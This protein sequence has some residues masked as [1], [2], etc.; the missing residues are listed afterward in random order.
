MVF[1]LLTKSK[2]IATL[3]F[4]ALLAYQHVVPP[5]T[6]VAGALG[7]G[8]PPKAPS[9]LVASSMWRLNCLLK[10]IPLLRKAGFT[11]NE[12]TGSRQ[13]YHR[14][15]GDQ[16][17]Q[18][19]LYPEFTATALNSWASRRQ[20]IHRRIIRPSK[21][22]STNNIRLPGWTLPRLTMVTL[23][24]ARRASCKNSV[25]QLSRNWHRRQRTWS[26]RLLAMGSPS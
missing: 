8:R 23:S 2:S 10:C 12:K 17:R 20:T 5:V 21:T 9:Q 16:Q 22:R 1:L 19:D 18:I 13:Q 7:G 11:V 4:V 24:V 14:L 26:S 25:Q 6:V 15:P 3:V